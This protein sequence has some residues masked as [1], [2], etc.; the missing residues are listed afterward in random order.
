MLDI[1]I[2]ELKP[3]LNFICF[4][5]FNL[6][7][8]VQISTARQVRKTL[9]HSRVKRLSSGLSID[10]NGFIANWASLGFGHRSN[11]GKGN[12][13]D[14][15]RRFGSTHSYTGLLLPNR[16]GLIKQWRKKALSTLSTSTTCTSSLY[17]NIKYYSIRLIIIIIFQPLH[18]IDIVPPSS[19]SFRAQVSWGTHRIARQVRDVLSKLAMA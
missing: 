4:C 14:S 17:N 1:K 8:L 11:E 13:F 6:T 15:L 19:R 16:R 2:F 18:L 10:R 5:S 12:G 7:I 9:N 3:K